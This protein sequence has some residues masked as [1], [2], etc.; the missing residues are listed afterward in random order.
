MALAHLGEWILRSSENLPGQT[1]LCGFIAGVG[2][3]PRRREQA[4]LMPQPCVVFTSVSGNS[5]GADPSS[6]ADLK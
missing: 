3:P 2:D 1:V 5:G 4:F 6:G